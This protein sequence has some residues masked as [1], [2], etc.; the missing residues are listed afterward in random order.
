MKI[1]IRNTLIQQPN[2]TWDEPIEEQVVTKME[3]AIKLYFVLTK[4]VVEKLAIFGTN[5]SP[6]MMGEVLMVEEFSDLNLVIGSHIIG[7]HQLVLASHSKLIAGEHYNEMWCK[8]RGV[9]YSRKSGNL[10]KFEE[11][12]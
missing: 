10:R 8:F 7:V 3:L 12:I 11:K 2:L 5:G 9:Y 6:E 1:L 4:E